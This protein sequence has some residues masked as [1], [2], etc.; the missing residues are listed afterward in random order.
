MH[1][2]SPSCLRAL[3]PVALLS[4]VF[5]AAAACSASGI[6]LEHGR[7]TVVT[8]E[9]ARH[10]PPRTLGLV[11]ENH[12][13][14]QRYDSALRRTGF[15]KATTPAIDALLDRLDSQGLLTYG[16]RVRE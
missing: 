16:V 8:L 6:E 12:P 10:D 3:A 13:G 11:S 7:P 4:A 14:V 9:D 2:G 5:S 1:R 15:K